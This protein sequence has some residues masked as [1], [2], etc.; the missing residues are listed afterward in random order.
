MHV[1]INILSFWQE[2]KL[3][4]LCIM[5]RDINN[6]HYHYVYHLFLM[7][8]KGDVIA[9]CHSQHLSFNTQLQASRGQ[10]RAGMLL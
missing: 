7:D 9:R 1:H 5:N 8:Y 6:L 4:F 3:L 2:Q 10:Q